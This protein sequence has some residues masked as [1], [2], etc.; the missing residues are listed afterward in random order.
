MRADG[1][2]PGELRPVKIIR[3]Y[4]KYPEG[5][6]LIEAG[7]TRVICT[8]TVEDRVPQWLKGS[9]QGWITAEYGMIPRAT[10]TRNLREASKG[11]QSGRTMEIQRLIGRALRSVVDLTTLGERT[12]W[13]DC[14]VI[15][16]DGGTRT[17]SITGSFVA[18]IDALLHIWQ[19][20][21]NLNWRTLPVTHYLAAVSAG[22]VEGVPLLDLNYA[23]DSVAQVD[24]NFVMTSG[25]RVIE[26]QGTAEQYP[27]TQEE[28]GELLALA[29]QGI[30]ELIA[31]QKEILGADAAKVGRWSGA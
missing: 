5:S 9:G 7:D 29:Q 11:K 15:Q 14:D 2:A 26:I 13:V 18:L 25:N 16:A 31:L 10:E 1:R 3:N 17:A 28:L 4:L 20:N 12:I 21:D 23:E 19:N 8:A 27:F 30:S 6:V 24:M 22:I